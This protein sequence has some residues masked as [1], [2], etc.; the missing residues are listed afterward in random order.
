M[1]SDDE[2]LERSIGHTSIETVKKSSEENNYL[3]GQVEKLQAKVRTMNKDLEDA[4]R[5][6][7]ILLTKQ[8]AKDSIPDASLFEE[9]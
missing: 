6:T 7:E 1:S 5:L 8:K 4:K 9:Q 2:F 3:S